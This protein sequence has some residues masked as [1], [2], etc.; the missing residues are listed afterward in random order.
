[1][2]S[3]PI[4]RVFAPA[5]GVGDNP[6][7]EIEMAARVNLFRMINEFIVLLLGGL[8]ILMAATRTVGVPSHPAIMMGL[9][10][11]FIMWAT[12]AWSRPGPTEPRISAGIR[13]GSLAIVGGLLIAIPLLSLRHESLLLGIAGGVLVVRGIVGGVL[14]LREG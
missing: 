13:A 12:R 5:R 7:G 4:Q 3:G 1:M 2:A 11:V 9:G 6:P 10:V 8:L 14:S